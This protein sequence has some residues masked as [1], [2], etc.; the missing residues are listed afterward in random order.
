[1]LTCIF[2]YLLTYELSRNANAG[3]IAAAVMAVIPAHMMR[4]VAGGYDNESVAVPL[5]RFVLAS[6]LVC[7]I[8]S[9][10]FLSSLS[11]VT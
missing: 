6:P 11:R 1:M 3:V 4:S 9:S 2:T 10:I 7:T 8:P 5:V